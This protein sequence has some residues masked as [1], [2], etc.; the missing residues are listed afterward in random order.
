M[1]ALAWYRPFHYLPTELWGIY[2]TLDG[3]RYLTHKL[4]GQMRPPF[5]VPIWYAVEILW[6]H[7]EFH[8]LVEA[9]S[10]TVELVTREPKYLPYYRHFYEV[11][12][13]NCLEE[14]LANRHV[15]RRRSLGGIKY[16]LY[17]FFNQQ[18]GR[19]REYR[20]FD[21]SIHEPLINKV[22][23]NE[24]NLLLN[25]QANLVDAINEVDKMINQRKVS[26]AKLSKLPSHDLQSH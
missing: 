20:R 9:F 18:P 25:D 1:E 7:E 12:W 10:A 11:A 16:F 14:A 3:L 21:R 26:N 2:I 5:P 19:Y 22:I 8:F 23:G 6:Q 17:T 13:P 15:L 4:Q 24:L